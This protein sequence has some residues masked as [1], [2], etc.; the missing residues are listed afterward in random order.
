LQAKSACERLGLR[1]SHHSGFLSALEALQ[2][3]TGHGDPFHIAAIGRDEQ[4]M[5]GDILA[6]ALKNDGASRNLLLLRLDDHTTA[7]S[8]CSALFW[9]SISLPCDNDAML[10]LLAAARA[11]VSPL[12][13]LAGRRVLVVDDDP[14]CRTAATALLDARG[15]RTEQA[16]NGAEACAMQAATPFDLI[17]MDIDMPELDGKNATRRIRAGN[18]PQPLILAVTGSTADPERRDCLAAGMNDFIAKPLQAAALDDSLSIW[19]TALP[20]ADAMNTHALHN[21]HDEPDDLEDVKA[22]FGPMFAELAGMYRQDGPPRIAAM[23]QAYSRH[24]P[25]ALAKLSHALGGSSASI[26]ARGLAARCKELEL[27]VRT[28]LPEDTDG[29]IA[30]IE[31]E[32]NR[33]ASRLEA[34]TASDTSRES[35]P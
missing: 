13:A 30:D 6:S 19:F 12:P 32:Y 31:H 24:D 21:G 25:A 3:G 26:G 29:R 35:T 34:M 9:K 22:D 11:V 23:R 33:I 16:A 14:V 18:A 15:C 4:G 27:L 8:P 17:L 7:D 20:S 1:L 28:G 5:D 2:Q 10:A